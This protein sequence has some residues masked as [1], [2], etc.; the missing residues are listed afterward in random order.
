MLTNG[1]GYL[2]P[3]PQK[4]TLFKFKVTLKRKCLDKKTRVQ[5]DSLLSFSD[6][7]DLTQNRLQEENSFAVNI[8]SRAEKKIMPDEKNCEN[9]LELQL[10]QSCVN[11][12]N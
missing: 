11:I 1:I 5:P 2:R 4:H 12:S 8:P 9:K 7:Y 3:L 6:S 10:E